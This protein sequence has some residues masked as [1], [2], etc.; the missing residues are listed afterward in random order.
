MFWSLATERAV[1]VAAPVIIVL[2]LA[3]AW[4]CRRLLRFSMVWS[5]LASLSLGG[6]VLA[7]FV[8]GRRGLEFDAID[9]EL[10]ASCS[11][12]ERLTVLDAQAVLN[13]VLYVPFTF[14]AA[15]ASRKAAASAAT[16][17]VF[18]FLAEGLQTAMNRGVCEIADII[19]NLA[20]V[21]VGAAAAYSVHRLTAIGRRERRQAGRQP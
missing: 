4:L 3:L 1:V 12:T 7:M 15:M 21:V 18:V 13:A 16:A 19:H 8:S 11:G 17:A 20:G 10:I 6:V 9:V 5:F 2:C 14:A